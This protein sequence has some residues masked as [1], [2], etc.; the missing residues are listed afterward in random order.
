MDLVKDGVNLAHRR[1][2]YFQYNIPD[3]Y[4]PL[5]RNIQ[6]APVES[7]SFQA[8]QVLRNSATLRRPYLQLY[9]ILD[10]TLSMSEKRHTHT[11]PL[12]TPSPQGGRQLKRKRVL[13]HV[14]NMVKEREF[15]KREKDLAAAERTA[16][17]LKAK[18]A[19]SLAA[20]SSHDEEKRAQRRRLHDDSSRRDAMLKKKRKS[21]DVKAAQLKRKDEW[22]DKHAKDLQHDKEEVARLRAEV[23]KRHQEAQEEIARRK[24]ERSMWE[25]EVK[26]QSMELKKRSKELDSREAGM[27]RKSL[28]LTRRRQ[29]LDKQSQRVQDELMEKTRR[30][31]GVSCAVEEA[32]MKMAQSS[33]EKLAPK[34]G[35]LLTRQQ[36]RC[37]LQL[38]FEVQLTGKRS[39]NDAEFLVSQ[40][41]E[42]DASDRCDALSLNNECFELVAHGSCALSIVLVEG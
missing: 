25:K 41:C 11:L 23:E 37:I 32:V 15:K 21:L 20:Q 31:L 22:H 40:Y 19:A 35:D 29:E 4:K 33:L 5:L 14:T 34:S 42:S 17:D 13:Q 28:E 9:T 18:L 27:T 38:Y 16:N 12:Q 1:L 7:Q 36:S 24:S 39:V 26:K 6:S 10:Q 3:K 8:S 30:S 2:Y